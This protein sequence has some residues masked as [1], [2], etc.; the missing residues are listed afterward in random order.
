MIEVYTFLVGGIE[1][2][3]TQNALIVITTFDSKIILLTWS[4]LTNCLKS[5]G[6]VNKNKCTSDATSRQ[7]TV[8][9]QDHFRYAHKRIKRGVQ[10]EKQ[11]DE[12]H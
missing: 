5:L 10:K 1:Y 7:I 4:F 12:N 2:T 6:A 3:S 11:L 8:A 9:V